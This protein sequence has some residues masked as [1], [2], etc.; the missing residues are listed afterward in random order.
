MKDQIHNLLFSYDPLL[1]VEVKHDA[2]VNNKVVYSTIEIK[3][4]K[5]YTFDDKV[6]LQE[7]MFAHVEENVPVELHI[8]DCK[9]NE[10]SVFV[11]FFVVLGQGEDHDEPDEI[12]S[13]VYLSCQ[14]VH[15][16]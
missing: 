9:I 8:I 13:F 12:P 16:A 5:G 11:K 4:L 3:D 14:I 10:E 15:T 6:A 7:E 1:N 2:T